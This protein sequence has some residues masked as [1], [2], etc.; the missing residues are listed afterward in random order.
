MSKFL[1][2][3]KVHYDDSNGDP[4]NGGLLYTYEVGTT[5][6]KATYPTIAD[7]KAATNANANPVVL[8]SRGEANV[9]LAGNTKLVLKTSAGST[10]WTVDN[11][12]DD[13]DILDAN[14]NEML[15]FTTAASATNFININS[16]ASGTG[17]TLTS[18]G[19]D[20]NIGL[21]I[22]TKGTGT[23]TL[24]SADTTSVTIAAANFV[25]NS[26]LNVATPLVVT[27]S[28]S[29][30]GE[31]RLNEDT[32]TGTNYISIKAPSAVTTTTTLILPDGDGTS[33]QYLSTNASGVLAWTTTPTATQ[34]E[35]ETATSTT[36]FATPGRVKY[37][38]G[39]AKAWVYFSYSA[40]TPTIAASL[41]VTSLTDTGT[42][43]AT[44]NLTTAFSSSSYCA[45]ATGVSGSGNSYAGCISS[46]TSASAYVA[47]GYNTS[48]AADTDL[49]IFTV[50][51][52]DQ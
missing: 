52:G 26:A 47:R 17:P 2:T 38:P 4:L 33:G 14:G 13:A 29:S 7:A 23:L 35:M 21:T 15:T 42:G 24:G 34:A 51:H 36:V 48:T 20:T 16:T 43:L 1:G 46:I 25:L 30:A 49:A 31:I 27:G 41:N 3:P 28:A 22:D 18:A 19:S 39:V 9:V 40:G 12:N 44:V 50:A 32:D 37:N 10:L 45:T 8:D 6:N 11:V 5:T